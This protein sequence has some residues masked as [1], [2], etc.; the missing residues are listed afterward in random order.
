[1]SIP[2]SQAIFSLFSHGDYSDLFWE[3]TRTLS[4]RWEDGKVERFTGGVD[5]GAGLRYQSG[6]ECRYAC[7]DD[8]EISAFEALA[9]QLTP[10]L[11]TRKP[12][13][14]LSPT[15]LFRPTYERPV[16]QIAAE[17]KVALLQRAYAAASLPGV[18]QITIGYGE[19]SRHVRIW[20]SEGVST[21][22]WRD[23]LTF[24]ITVVAEKNGLLQTAYDSV[25]GTGGF[26]FFDANNVV[27]LARR[28]AERAVLRLSAPAAPLGEM[29]VIIAASAGGTLI[30]EAIG[31]P[32]EAD[33]VQKDVSP[34]YKGSVG[35]V[36]ADEKVSVLEDPTM[37]GQRG[38]YAFDDEGIQA[39]RVVTAKPRRSIVW[40]PT[41]M[42]AAN[43]SVIVP[44]R[45]WRTHL[46]R[47]VRM[48]RK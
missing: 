14:A 9:Q 24:S 32:L 15:A 27:T 4:I 7:V 39:Q 30:H 21:E 28:V 40:R 26:E 48:I 41:V 2:L 35:K 22:E 25:S 44:S 3:D 33:A 29:P 8:P 19:N 1:V 43:R 37:P 45:A 17:A 5:R 31:H 23:T 18:R 12:P 34:T 38:F 16:E 11:A 36:V 10:G 47:R 6:D 13:R 42:A 20:T 46:S